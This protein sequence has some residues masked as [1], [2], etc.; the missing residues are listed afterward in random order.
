MF[1]AQSRK[2]D[3][4][5]KEKDEAQAGPTGVF[6]LNQPGITPTKLRYDTQLWI[7]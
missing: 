5:G 1:S 3:W 4:G 7:D 2:A 6:V